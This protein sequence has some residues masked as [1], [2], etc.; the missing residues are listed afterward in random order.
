MAWQGSRRDPIREK[1]HPAQLADM[2]TEEVRDGRAALVRSR[3]SAY[4][5]SERGFVVRE[6]AEEAI[7]GCLVTAEQLASSQFPRLSYIY[8]VLDS[9]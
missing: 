1:T 6:F 9:R 2:M 4:P 3:S 8:V 5:R 7:R